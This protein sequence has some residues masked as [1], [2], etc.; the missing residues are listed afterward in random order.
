METEL[1]Q[2]KNTA[3]D[4]LFSIVREADISP[5]AA[6]SII[7]GYTGVIAVRRARPD[8]RVASRRHMHGTVTIPHGLR[9]APP[10]APVPR[11]TR[12]AP[13]ETASV[14]DHSA[15]QPARRVTR[16]PPLACRRLRNAPHYAIRA[17]ARYRP[18]AIA[19]SRRTGGE[20]RRFCHYSDQ[21]YIS[22]VSGA[23]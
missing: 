3:L 16:G 12:S 10:P 7:D 6:R 23:R 8:Q 15:R 14:R 20:G 19:V 2:H 11:R 9:P 1:V 22:G 4:Y 13:S 5:L 17:P 18:I 21:Y